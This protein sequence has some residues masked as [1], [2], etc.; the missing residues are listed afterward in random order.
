MLEFERESGDEEDEFICET[1]KI[2]GE[3]KTAINQLHKDTRRIF[4]L[5]FGAVFVVTT[6]TPWIPWLLAF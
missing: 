1:E 3:S 4:I 6:V 5:C 2:N